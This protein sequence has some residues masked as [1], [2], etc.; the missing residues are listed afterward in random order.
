M[1]SWRPVSSRNLDRAE[2][3]QRVDNVL[4]QHLRRRSA[5]GD[6]DR[7]RAVEPFR[8]HFAAVGDEI[9][10]RAGLVADLAQPVGIGTV[11]GADHQN[12]VHQRRE[13]AHRGLA[14]LRGVADVARFRADDVGK[15]AMQRGDD[16]ARVVDAQRRLR[17]VGDRR[18]VGNI[19]RVDVVLGLHQ[20]HRLGNL[21]HRAFDLRMAGVADQ[22][23][24]AALRDIA[25]AL[26][27]HLG[28][29]RAGGVE[30][31]ELALR[32]FLLDALGDAMGAEDGDRVRRNLGEVLDEM[33][34]FG[35]EAL[36]DMLVVHDLVAHIDRRAVFLQG[37]LDDLDGADDA[38]AKTARL[39]EYNLHQ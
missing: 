3:A 2:P 39:S 17:H 37:A 28:D 4:H 9:A 20:C 24:P 7:L 25:L 34:A 5:G 26:I 13:F 14:V 21:A 11:L 38:R 23:E 22:N 18:I 27:V 31:R 29:Q 30:H 33:R 10:G 1:V 32:G 6:A 12:N 35:L 8:L 16:A 19:E 15:P 36:D